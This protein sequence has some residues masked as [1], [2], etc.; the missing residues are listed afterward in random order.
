MFCCI[1]WQYIPD[2]NIFISRYIRCS[3]NRFLVKELKLSS[4]YLIKLIQFTARFCLQFFGVNLHT[5]DSSLLKVWRERHSRFAK[6]Q[7][8]D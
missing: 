4:D 6:E 8:G 1:V 5:V 7:K 2:C 3:R